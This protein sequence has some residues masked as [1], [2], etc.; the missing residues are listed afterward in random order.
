MTV[1]HAY[2]RIPDKTQLTPTEKEN[3]ARKKYATEQNATLKKD[4]KG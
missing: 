3:A 2:R 4:V 1:A